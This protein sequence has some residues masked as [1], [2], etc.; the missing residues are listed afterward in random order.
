MSSEPKAKTEQ[1]DEFERFKELTRKLLA[2]PKKELGKTK[3]TKRKKQTKKD[4]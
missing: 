3:K 4:S 2:V 1:D